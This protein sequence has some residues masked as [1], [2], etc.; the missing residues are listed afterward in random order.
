MPRQKKTTAVNLKDASGL[1]SLHKEPVRP[2]R[3]RQDISPKAND[4]TKITARQAQRGMASR[5]NSTGPSTGRG[6]R[7]DTNP[8][9]TGN[10]RVQ[11][12]HTNPTGGHGHR[13]ASRGK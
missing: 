13:K 10:R 5:A 2:K 1:K 6:D 8:M 9:Y 3:G 12:N 4:P 7:R 11:A